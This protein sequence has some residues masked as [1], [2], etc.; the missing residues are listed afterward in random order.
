MDTIATPPRPDDVAAAVR[1]ALEEDVGSGDVTARLVAPRATVSASVVCR[2][3]AV[4]CGTAWFEEVF[5]Q[6]DAD[7]AVDWRA[8]DGDA[9]AADDVACTVTGP[10]APILTG[11]RT[12]LNF[13][14]LLSGTATTARDYARAVEGSRTRVLDTRKTLPGLRIAQKY[15]VRCGGCHN[16][17]QGLFD[18]V[19]IKDNHIANAGSIDKVVAAARRDNPNLTVEVE[20]TDLAQLDEALD[21]GADIIML[22]NFERTEM[23]EAVARSRGRARLEISGNVELEDLPALA[24]TGVDYVSVG[25]LTKHVRAVDFSMRFETHGNPD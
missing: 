13:L 17:R 14:Q 9:L 16:H 3:S 11:E 6:L 4:L 12:A 21:A 1:R 20:V 25:A 23:R 24:A 8:A 15:A 19:L 5:R 2:E 18:A 10:A 7:I 22:D